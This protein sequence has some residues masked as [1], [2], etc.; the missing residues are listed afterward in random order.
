MRASAKRAALGLLSH[1]KAQLNAL[2]LRIGVKAA[3]LKLL[4]A[5]FSGKTY[6]S[7]TEAA[8]WKKADFLRPDK[9]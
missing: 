1:K 9:S 3:L 5:A 6:A 4:P 7:R 2:F 8:K